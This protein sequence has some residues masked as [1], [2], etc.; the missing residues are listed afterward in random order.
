MSDIDHDLAEARQALDD[1]DLHGALAWIEIHLHGLQQLAPRQASAVLALYAPVLEAW[2][3]NTPARLAREASRVVDDAE[4]LFRLGVALVEAREL[5]PA[6]GVLQRAQNHACDVDILAKIIHE[7]CAADEL[8]GQYER[9]AARIEGAPAEVR[10]LPLSRYLHAF[11]RLAMRDPGPARAVFTALIASEDSTLVFMGERLRAMLA[12]HDVLAPLASTA[13]AAQTARV[14]HAIVTGELA[15]D[16][17]GAERETLASVR[18]R[19]CALKVTLE[20]LGV[21]PE[22]VTSPDDR[23][24]SILAHA[25][26]AVLG[27]PFS[28]EAPERGSALIVVWDLAALSEHARAGLRTSTPG[29]L[30]YVHAGRVEEELL[31]GADLIGVGGTM[32][33][34]GPLRAPW[35]HNAEVYALAHEPT[36]SRDDRPLAEIADDVVTAEPSPIAVVPDEELR[37]FAAHIRALPP[38]ARPAGLGDASRPRGRRW[39]RAAR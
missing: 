28:H 31:L 14:W 33:Q 15:L 27:V 9:A 10:S 34:D 35:G 39:R 20:G 17:E 22:V 7:L 4:T 2:C 23:D 5:E 38:W 26:A 24:A 32:T 25:A 37:V 6:I 18:A 13:S 8:C 29:E 11:A 21:W 36:P 16:L 3:G 19:L 30:L 12:R 1:E